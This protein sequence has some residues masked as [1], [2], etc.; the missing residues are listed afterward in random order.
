MPSGSV[1][2]PVTPTVVPLAEFSAI[3]FADALLSTG[4][5]GEAFIASLINN[6]YESVLVGTVGIISAVRWTKN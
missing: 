6:E 5:E 2:K 4:T 3:E 1:E